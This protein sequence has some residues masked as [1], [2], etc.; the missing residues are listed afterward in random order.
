[1]L[2]RWARPTRWCVSLL[3]AVGVFYLIRF[4]FDLADT[5]LAGAKDL[6]NRDFANYWV[7][8]K[9]VHAGGQQ[10]LFTLQDYRLVLEAFF[11]REYAT[12]A[13]SYPPHFLLFVWPLGLVGYKAALSGFLLITFALF[14]FAAL[15]FRHVYAPRSDGTLFAATLIG[16]AG[17][18]LWL[19]QNGFFTAGCALLGLA[20]IKQRPLLAGLALACL[21]TKPQLG[22]LIPVLLLVDRNWPTMIWATVFTGALVGIS[23]A[24]FGVGSWQAYLGETMPYQAHVLTSWTGDFLL[25]M[26]NVFGSMRTLDL[27]PTLAFG[28]Q[29]IASAMFGALTIWLLLKETDPLGRICIVLCGTFLV[30]PYAF[31]YDMGAFAVAAAVL[32]GSRRL[33]S[34]AT[35]VVAI[36]AGLP[37]A[38]F[39]LGKASLPITPLLLAG[40]LAAIHMRAP[41]ETSEVVA[42]ASIA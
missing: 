1:M 23:I 12:H 4:L 42:D 14:V 35:F 36:A 6:A 20:W 25:M 34:P 37:A 24:L 3:A 31:N 41:R 33:A 28:V 13:W 10:L 16:F 21:T 7:A 17:M 19:M 39:A 11:G 22:L 8:G 15:T 38:V 40:C 29:G 26:P 5:S 9:L 30:S 32:A 2:D 27:S 18:M